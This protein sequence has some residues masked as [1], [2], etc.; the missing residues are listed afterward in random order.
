VANLFGRR[1]RF[2]KNRLR[3]ISRRKTIEKIKSRTRIK[4]PFGNILLL[5]AA[6]TSVIG[7][8]T[9]RRFNIVNKTHVEGAEILHN[10]PKT[11][12]LFISNH[13]TYYADVIALYHIFGKKPEFCIVS[14][15]A[16]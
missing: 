12:V 15:A 3:I 16:T 7:L 6:L 11:N 2:K 4:D 8:A 5:K 1:D 9:Y 14:S 13:Q 10:L